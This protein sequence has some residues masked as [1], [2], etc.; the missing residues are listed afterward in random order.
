M[1]RTIRVRH[2][3]RV[4]LIWWTRL[5]AAA[6]LAIAIMLRSGLSAEAATTA[7]V[8][9]PL[10]DATFRAPGFMDIVGADTVLVGESIQF[11]M[12]VAAAV[13]AE[14]PPTPPGSNQIEWDFAV[15]TDPSTFPAGNPF[16]SG[17]GQA[18]AAEFIVKVTWDGSSFSGFLIDRR[19]LL[20]GGEATITPLAF[21]I[22]GTDIQVDVPASLLP[23]SFFWGAVTFYWSSP[24]GGTAGGHFVDALQPFYTAFPA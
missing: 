4:L 2:I 14:P 5:S 13:P 23:S 18:R 6:V 19:P 8:V 12:S 15:D 10:G 3:R 7:S 22:S 17:P 24:P 1:A 11:Q 16:P 9:D 21:S 20:S